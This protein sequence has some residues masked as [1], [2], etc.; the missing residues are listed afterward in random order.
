MLVQ[1]VALSQPRELSCFSVDTSEFVDRPVE[2]GIPL[3]TAS[4]RIGMTENKIRAQCL[5]RGVAPKVS[6][7]RDL[8]PPVGEFL[9]FCVVVRCPV[10]GVRAVSGVPARARLDA[11]ARPV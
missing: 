5:R 4:N 3:S 9:G 10:R 8:H 7:V 1:S 11:L 2:K 6:S